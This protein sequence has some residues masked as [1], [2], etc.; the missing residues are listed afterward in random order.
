MHQIHT[1]TLLLQRF[2]FMA[3]GLLLSLYMAQMSVCA[4]PTGTASN[5]SA[6]ALELAWFYKPPE[7]GTPISTLATQVQRFV[8][9]PDDEEVRD[10]LKNFNVSTSILQYV[11]FDAIE[12]PCHKSCPCSKAP[13]NNQV[14]WNPGD[15]CAIQLDHP[16][17]FLRTPEGNVIDSWTGNQRHVWMDPGNLG[18]REFWLSRVKNAQEKRGWEGVFLDNVPASL[19]PFAQEGIVLNKYRD[20][21]SFQSAVKGFLDSIQKSYFIPEQR[22]L[23]G[24]IIFL[25]WTQP[26]STWIAF[27]SRMDGAMMEDFAVGWESGSFKTSAQWLNQMETVEDSQKIGKHVTLVA[28]G[29]QYDF[30]RQNFALASYLLVNQGAASYRYSNSQGQYESFWWY[31]NYTQARKLGKA[32]TNRYQNPNGS[33]ARDF[34][35]GQV[36]VDPEKHRFNIT[37]QSTPTQSKTLLH[38]SGLDM[39]YT[40]A[41]RVATEVRIR[42]ASNRY[43]PANTQVSLST[44]LPNGNTTLSIGTVDEYG[45][46]TFSVNSPLKGTYTS[47]VTNVKGTNADFDAGK[48]G[49]NEVSQ[50]IN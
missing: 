42:D 1:Y 35:F 4:Q 6:T 14:A 28:Q 45:I 41:Y 46:V 11:R 38:V 44:Q 20:D 37:I 32:I 17:W 47:T 26:K 3:L 40:Q 29:D 21:A 18:W 19:D 5:A 27:I 24:N 34:E 16:D 8:L 7:D 30:D 50:S 12:D 22:P 9:S 48:S 39:W 25:P 36:M 43:P 10:Q 33:W 23:E 15:F 13:W 49:A 2:P 31:G